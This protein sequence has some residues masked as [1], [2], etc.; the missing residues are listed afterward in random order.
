M[1]LEGATQSDWSVSEMRDMRWKASGGHPETKPRHEEVVGG[2]VDEDYIP[3]S[4]VEEGEDDDKVGAPVR[5][6]KVLTSVT[7]IEK[8]A[9]ARKL[10]RP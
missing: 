7:R 1:W 6:T 2:V 3:I 5:S 10:K 9:F 4:E 8:N